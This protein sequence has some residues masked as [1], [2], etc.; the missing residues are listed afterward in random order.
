MKNFE[1]INR[2]WCALIVESLTRQGITDFYV[3]PGMRNA[4]MIAAITYNSK[5]NIIEG[6]DE[7]SLSY[8][9]LGYSKATNRAACL[10]CTSGT[11][12]ANFY[13][14]FIEAKRDKLPLI[15]ISSDRPKE[16]SLVDANQ[17]IDQQNLFGKYS[18]YNLNLDAPSD[19]FPVSA[20]TKAIDQLVH[21]AHAPIFGPVHLNLPLREPLDKT[22]GPIGE[23]FKKHAQS[24]FEN[25]SLETTYHKN[26]LTVDD[27]A[28]NLLKEKI[29][30][31]NSPLFIVGKNTAKAKNEIRSFFEENQF[32]AFFDVS[33]S[34]KYLF[35][36]KSME[37]TRGIPS[38][39]HPEVY[40][41]FNTHL[42]D[43]IIH[44]GGRLTGKH[45]YRY[46]KENP[47]IES[48]L[49]SESMDLEDTGFSYHERYECELGSFLSLLR[50]ELTYSHQEK[51]SCPWINFVETKRELIENGPLS[52]PSIS[53]TL[54]EQIPSK[55]SVFIANSTAIRSFDS[56]I[57]PS[58]KKELQ[59]F[60]NRGVSGIEG[61]VSTT[62]GISDALEKEVTLVT[63]DVSLFHDLNALHYFKE[64]KKNNLIILVNNKGG[65]IF[66]LL[67]IASEKEILAP[68]IT[69][70]NINFGAICSAFGIQY[71]KV[72]TSNE[73]SQALN[74]YYEDKE[75]TL[76]EVVLDNNENIEVYKKLKTVKL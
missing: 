51:E 28:V 73:Y 26:Y 75:K 61:M 68:M 7:R 62:L 25:D 46:L 6:I 23:T 59:I 54:I 11:A 64:H 55:E 17:T 18:L 24:Y 43:L 66:T 50:K 20:L 2:L 70:H 40:E 47:Q 63:G 15:V 71:K 45:Y 34:V 53:K 29:Q 38:M 49:I 67:P 12:M 8:R 52:F 19:S 21:R 9:A 58:E 36:L 57:H 27:S 10:V 3:A 30:R 60:C 39:D 72:Q 32:D 76:I 42:P 35:P 13:P 33:S 41:Y 44:L 4:P 14:A 48:I 56:F 31:A 37:R 16:L 69:E 22:K 65:G 5:A 1:N 74:N